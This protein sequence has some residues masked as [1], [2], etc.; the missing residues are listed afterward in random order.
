MKLHDAA[1]LDLPEWLHELVARTVA[2]MYEAVLGGEITPAQAEEQL[3]E[4]VRELGREVLSVGLSERYGRHQGTHRPCDCGANQRF[5][6]YRTRTMMTL[7]GPLRYER[8]YYRCSACKTGH[9]IGDDAIGLDE[10]SCSLP[11]QE[12]ISLVGCELPFEGARNL[13]TRLTGLDV[14]NSH[15][16]RVAEEHGARLEQE[17]LAERQAL[18]AGELKLLPEGAPNRLYVVLDGLKMLF[19]DDWHETK[20]GSVYETKAG[21]D[22]IDEP[23]AVTHVCGAWE[24][25][26]QFG[27]RLYQEAARR[28]VE[29][30]GELVVIAD[31][32]PWIW[33]LVAEHFPGAVQILDFFHAAERLYEV[34]RAVYGEGTAQAREWAEAN[35][36][37]LWQGR[38]DGVLRSLRAVRPPPGDGREA[39]RLARGY[40]AANRRR[41]DYPSYRARGYHVGSG[42]VEAACK[43][44]AAARCKRSGMRWTKDGA[45]SVLSLRCQLLNARWDQYWKPL[46]AAA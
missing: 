10:H 7:L 14:S 31:G 33:N 38:V 22:G 44:V 32:A 12:A 36:E 26:E 5:M 13:L 41:M 46:K 1:T 40:F 37:R 20:I 43:T 15:V 34:G 8:A 29:R 3:L 35:K 19:V 16:R 18:F 23:V 39:V 4:L 28:G 17:A 11:A 25:P 42:V 27:E 6:G 24:G 9:H 2:Q 45:Q 30:A 21:K